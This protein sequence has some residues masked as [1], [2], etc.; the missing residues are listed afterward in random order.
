MLEIRQD[1]ESKVTYR[2]LP[3]EISALLSKQNSPP[4]LVAHLT[5]VHDVAMDLVAKIEE[6]KIH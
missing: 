6:I 5:L 4:R 1:N 2:K 3:E